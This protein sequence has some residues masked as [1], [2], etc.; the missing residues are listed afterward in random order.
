MK[1]KAFLMAALAACF[2]F[3]GCD[4]DQ[5]LDGLTPD[6]EQTPD[7]GEEGEDSGENTG[8]EISFADFLKLPN[9]DTTLYK[10]SGV[11]WLIDIN[12][13]EEITY[14]VMGDDLYNGDDENCISILNP[15][16]LENLEPA[17]RPG[18]VLTVNGRKGEMDK[19]GR[20]H[21]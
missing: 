14:I 7:T 17:L 21:V 11:V 5:I 9:D 20:A 12:Y 13:R 18:Q 6:T 1:L 10:V 19:I 15:T 16:W 4:M 2:V 3:V 8:T